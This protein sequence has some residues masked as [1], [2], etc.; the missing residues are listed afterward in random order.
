MLKVL[1]L[2]LLVIEVV[3][4]PCLHVLHLVS[5]WQGQNAGEVGLFCFHRCFED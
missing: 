3:N 4:S 5:V 1:P 2:L